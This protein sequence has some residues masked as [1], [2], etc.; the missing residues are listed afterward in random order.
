MLNWFLDGQNTPALQTL[1]RL[2]WLPIQ[3]KSEYKILTIT[4]KCI[5]GQVLQCLK[6]LITMN[7]PKCDNMISNNKGA[8]LAISKVKHK[9]FAACLFKYSAPLL[10]NH[11]PQHIKESPSIDICKT[12][13]KT[14]LCHMTFKQ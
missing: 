12:K 5:R 1:K 11:L 8:T 3:Q 7:K 2:H 14:H 9:A 13:V 4:Y 10:W 6:D